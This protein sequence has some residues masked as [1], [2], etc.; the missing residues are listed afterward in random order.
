[1][2][3][4]LGRT[5]NAMLGALREGRETKPAG[6][7]ALPVS[8]QTRNART[9]QVEVDSI[10]TNPDQP[11]R[12]FDEAELTALTES[13]ER[14]GLLEPI[15]VKPLPNGLYQLAY[16]ER[17]LRAV[18]ALG[19]PTIT[20]VVLDAD[21]PTDEIAL[22]ENLLRSDLNPFEVAD[23]FARII[24]TRGWSQGDISKH[25]GIA[26]SE[27]SRTLK[28]LDLPARIR[29]EYL[30][31]RV[32]MKVLRDIADLKDADAQTTAWDRAKRTYAGA[33]VEPGEAKATTTKLRRPSEDPA[34]IVH[35]SLPKRIARNV[36]ATR[37]ALVSLRT[38]PTGKPLADTDRT[39][40]RE[41]RDAIDA[42]LVDEPVG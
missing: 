10:A 18:R 2:S 36:L 34:E 22:V 5:N 6:E 14:Y 32:P 15:G 3:R 24:A 35:S 11:R 7:S 28:V 19:Q 27:V 20:A 25:F 30:Q 17:R 9:A 21:V 29:A 4:K 26:K 16:G 1:M 38:E 42:L 37:D 39:M 33:E 12:D 23:G 40:L 41:M 31:V 8:F 13:I